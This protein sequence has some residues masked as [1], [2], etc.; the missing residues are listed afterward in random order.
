M[1]GG[2]GEGR[3][4]PSSSTPGRALCPMLATEKMHGTRSEKLL[5]SFGM[6]VE[7]M[8]PRM[9]GSRYK[10][11]GV[12]ASVADLLCL[13]TIAPDQLAPLLFPPLFLRP[14]GLSLCRGLRLLFFFFSGV[15]AL[16][17][18]CR[19]CCSCWRRP[20]GS[21]WPSSSPSVKTTRE[22]KNP[23]KAPFPSYG[24]SQVPGT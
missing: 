18:A 14:R 8:F 16:T 21:T 13:D 19:T 5:Q 22:T 6:A 11:C 12:R 3:M 7:L 23:R 9:E 1:P 20:K 15:A 4:S 24:L 2:R 17:T 10:G